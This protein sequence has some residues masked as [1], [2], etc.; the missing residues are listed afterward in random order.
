MIKLN[1]LKITN[2]PITQQS[3]FL[4]TKSLACQLCRVDDSVQSSHEWC[5]Y[6]FVLLDLPITSLGNC[7]P[8]R[9]AT[10]LLRSGCLAAGL[11]AGG[12]RTSD[13]DVTEHG[14]PEGG[15]SAL[16][17]WVWMRPSVTSQLRPPSLRGTDRTT[18][19]RHGTGPLMKILGCCGTG[20][21]GLSSSSLLWLYD[22]MN[23][24]TDCL[25]LLYAL[26]IP[27]D[28]MNSS[29]VLVVTETTT[30]YQTGC[31]CLRLYFFTVQP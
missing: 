29:V 28:D 26:K 27:A 9:R 23:E 19:G 16:L 4:Q 17:C 21:R 7:A 11:P 22:L 13:D 20:G 25:F 14:R 2:R 30:N 3:F 15:A 6:V 10:V 24:R 1:K 12:Q 5:S 31:I 18:A 8:W